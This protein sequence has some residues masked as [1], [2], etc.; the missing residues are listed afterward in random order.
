MLQIILGKDTWEIVAFI[1]FLVLSVFLLNAVVY[2]AYLPELCETQEELVKHRAYV[3]GF[4]FAGEI[5]FVILMVIII[6]TI[7]SDDVYIANYSSGLAGSWLLFVNV[8]VYARLLR[9]REATQTIPEGR[10]AMSAGV[11]KLVDTIKHINRVYPYLLRYLIG[12]MF[13]DGAMSVFGSIATNYLLIQLGMSGGDAMLVIL[14]LLLT[15]LVVSPFALWMSK[16]AGKTLGDAH[17]GMPLL[18]GAIFYMTI[19]T[20]VAPFALYQ[21][22]EKDRAYIFAVLWGFGMGIYYT[23]EKATYFF[24]IPPSQAAKFSGLSMFAG[25]IISWAPL[26]SFFLMYEQLGT[27]Q[28]GLAVMGGYFLIG[29][30][31][32]MSI[33]IE[34]ARSQ[35]LQGDAEEGEGIGADI[36]INSGS[37]MVPK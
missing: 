30:L 21:P 8:Y 15:A 25:K 23:L 14:T 7:E 27:M 29:G 20:F 37:E 13:V 22:D 1:Q 31:L 4:M 16:Y 2:S 32:F 36:G 3:T 33:D 5:I 34:T 17:A 35:A 26:L 28:Y 6:S 11:Y 9:R 18:I 12:L 19:I 10:T 24:I